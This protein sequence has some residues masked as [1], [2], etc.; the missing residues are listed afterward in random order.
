MV[1]RPRSDHPRAWVDL[2]VC[3]HQGDLLRPGVFECFSWRYM[4]DIPAEKFDLECMPRLILALLLVC[5]F[6]I[7]TELEPWF[8][9][10]NAPR[11]GSAS[12]LQM[13]LGDSRRLFANH[14]FA[15]ADAYFHS[16]YYP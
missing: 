3:L 1:R 9:N 8:Q 4:D 14:F 2:V 13:L 7:A 12:V 11:N 16:G 5:C 10:W 15:K 6:T